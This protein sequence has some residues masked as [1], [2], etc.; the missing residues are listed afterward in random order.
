[1]IALLQIKLRK[2]SCV[3]PIVRLNMAP[4]RFCKGEVRDITSLSTFILT[5]K[6]DGRRERRRTRIWEKWPVAYDEENKQ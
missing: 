4:Y 5:S 2:K 1:M 3:K 6:E